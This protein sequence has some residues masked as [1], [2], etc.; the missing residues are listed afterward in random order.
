MRAK[1]EICAWDAVISHFRR[2]HDEGKGMQHV[3][4]AD[5][6]VAPEMSTY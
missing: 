1:A 6:V 5:A 3:V 4:D 2:L